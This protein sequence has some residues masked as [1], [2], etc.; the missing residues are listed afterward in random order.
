MIRY[1]L[2]CLVV[3]ILTGLTCPAWGQIYKYTDDKGHTIFTDDLSR[4]PADKRSEALQLEELKTVTNSSDGGAEAEL[5]QVLKEFY[6]EE[7]ETEAEAARPEFDRQTLED[8]RQKIEAEYLEL[9]EKKQELEQQK[10]L[11]LKRYNTRSDKRKHKVRYNRLSRQI[12]EM[13]PEIIEY[14]NRLKAI[15]TRLED[16]AEAP[17]GTSP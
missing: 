2:V 8:E 11:E 5:E 13:E 17:P 4:V 1:I 15:D 9:V 16:L 7:T 10:A 14:R 12:R 6:Q 3:M